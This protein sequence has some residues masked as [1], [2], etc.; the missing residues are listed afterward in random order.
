[1][2]IPTVN[3][4]ETTLFNAIR[5]G[6]LQEVQGLMQNGV[7]LDCKNDN[8]Q[9][10]LHYAAIYGELTIV[11]LLL[12]KGAKVDEKDSKEMTPLQMAVLSKELLVT[13]VLL[14][15]GA[16]VEVKGHFGYSPLHIAIYDNI[17]LVKLLLEHGADA[18]SP[19]DNE[20]VPLIRTICRKEYGMS[21]LLLQHGAKPDIK[22]RHGPAVHY[23]I[24]EEDKKTFDMILKY[25]TSLKIKNGYGE[26]PL[27]VALAKKLEF[28]KAIS[29]HQH[30]C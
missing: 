20:I 8:D 17:S 13:K 28:L 18:N 25:V 27:E 16:D 23:A 12:G 6:N 9:T 19:A 30:C 21:E 14:K 1:M 4:L 3:E 10:P 26:T 5:Y 2:E 22:Y 29:H 7:N 11:E 24:I 15:H